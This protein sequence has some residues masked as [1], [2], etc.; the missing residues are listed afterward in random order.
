MIG[1]DASSLPFDPEAMLEGLRP[2]VQCE[3]P[4]WDDGAVNRMMD[5][6][7]ADF[8]AAGA[9]VERLAGQNGFGDFLRVR[10]WPN[11]SAGP[12]I[13]VL[14]HFDT[15]HPVGTLEELPWRRDGDKC[16]GPGILDMK[17]GNYLVLEAFRQLNA[18]GIVPH[19][20]VTVLFTSDEEVGSPTSRTL[21]EEEARRSRFV[22]VPEPAR[23]D[24]SVVTGRYAIARVQIETRGQPTHAGN[25]PR[26][27]VSA[28]REMADLIARVEDLSDEYAT[29]SV[30]IIRGGHFSNCVATS[31][32]AEALLMARSVDAL[33]TLWHQIDALAPRRIGAQI[34]ATRGLERPIWLSGGE[35]PLYTHAQGICRTMG[36]E[37]SSNISGGGSDANY[38]GALG[39]PTLDGLGARGAM[40]HTLEEHIVVGSL[41]E[42][43]RLL[44]GLFATLR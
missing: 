28:I 6:A 23:P 9:D 11:A 20:P 2:W 44:A 38:T 14:G 16:F 32:S 30:G 7:A 15:V 37:L 26:N 31:C 1:F 4:S 27:G 13:L 41:A 33:E 10:L 8:T 17:S 40:L 24:G 35:G 21:I 19:L 5:L 39:I 34:V 3:S 42:R 43:G 29:C 18:A 12:G 22:L 25:G 36:F